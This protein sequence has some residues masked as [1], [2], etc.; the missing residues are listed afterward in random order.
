MSFK[1]KQLSEE[2][3][4][5]DLNFRKWIG[6]FEPKY[7]Q[8]AKLMLS[9]LK[10]INRDDFAEWII[11]RLGKYQS[12]NSVAVYAVRKFKKTCK[13]LWTNRGA[14]VSRPAT[15]QG[16][17]DFVASVVSNANRRFGDVF[18]DH[19][20]ISQLREKRIKTILLIDDSIGSGDRILTFFNLM[21]SNKTFLS[22]WSGGFIQ[23]KIITYARTMQAEKKIY[24]KF[25]GTKRQ[26][27]KINVCDKIQFDS[28]MI[29][30]AMDLKHRW[31]EEFEEIVQLCNSIKPIDKQKRLGY[32]KVM[33]NIIFYHSVPNNIPG[34]LFSSANNWNP[35]FKMRFLPGWIIK[36]LEKTTDSKRKNTKIYNHEKTEMIQLLTVIKR[37]VRTKASLA[38]LLECNLSNVDYKIRKLIKLGFLT[39]KNRITVVGV[40][41]LK[42]NMNMKYNKYDN[43]IYVPESWC[44]DKVSV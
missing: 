38:R 19:P 24:D 39:E 16:S 31:G 25:L 13:C 2:E 43:S 1:A 11:E 23:I 9:R 26:V 15:T 36:I 4:S 5:N 37:G 42:K 17:E 29:Y 21:M 34:L 18:L 32:G 20:S 22:W 14:I 6:Q 30:D 33:S 10:F 3:I 35:L 27:R 8:I 44:V 7:Q 12:A 41:F 40:N 28:E